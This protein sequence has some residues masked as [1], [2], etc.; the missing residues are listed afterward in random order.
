MKR[1]ANRLMIY[2]VAIFL[3]GVVL[4]LFSMN[5][6]QYFFE[7]MQ[8][9]DVFT[10]SVLRMLSTIFSTSVIPLGTTFIA[11]SV[12][13]RMLGRHLRLDEP[14]PTADSGATAGTDETE[15]AEES[16]AVAA[17]AVDEDAV[18]TFSDDFYRR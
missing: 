11:A 13:V 16:D 5:L 12:V 14:R 18:Q 2:G 9:E 7:K 15:A 1:I 8:P 6:M 17:P 10:A 4:Q 3:V